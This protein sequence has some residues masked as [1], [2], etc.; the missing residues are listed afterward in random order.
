VE[1]PMTVQRVK[2]DAQIEATRGKV[3][4]RYGPLVYTVERA[5]QLRTDLPL[6]RAAVVPE[7][8]GELLGGVTV[9]RGRWQ[10]GTPMT[11]VP[12]YARANRTGVPVREFP[13][14][15]GA[16]EYAPGAT[17]SGGTDASAEPAQAA[18]DGS[19]D[20]GVWLTDIA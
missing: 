9:L 7:W 19:Q 18:R 5:D 6:G 15:E 16:V 4:L 3:A 11:A 12:Y 20:A 13:R 14:G 2:G 8:R 10:G 1:L 17:R